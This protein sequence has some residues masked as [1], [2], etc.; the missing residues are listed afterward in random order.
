VSK[1][2]Q[3]SLFLS[4][5]NLG[6]AGHPCRDLDQLLSFAQL[7]ARYGHLYSTRSSRENGVEFGLR[8][9]GLLFIEGL[10][11]LVK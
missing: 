5:D 6:P 1:R 9:L 4:L 8:A 2:R 10:S 11:V 7:S 3:H